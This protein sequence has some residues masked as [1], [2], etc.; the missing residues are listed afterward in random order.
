MSS[1]VP[2]LS[3]L[4][5][6]G[7]VMKTFDGNILVFSNLQTLNL[8]NCGVENAQNDHFQSLS[9]LCLLDLRGCPLHRFSESLFAGLDKLGHIY[10]YSYKYKVYCSDVLPTNFKLDDCSAPGVVVSSC[11]SL[12]RS[13][14]HRISMPVFVSLAL[15]GHVGSLVACA[16]VT[17]HALSSYAVRVCH[18]P[19]VVRLCNGLAPGDDWRG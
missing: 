5:L 10:A 19:V 12:L 7:V 18:T 6:S 3:V 8:S 15:A 14:V 2:D 17:T 4:D 16:L 11:K 13:N 9:S 1:Y